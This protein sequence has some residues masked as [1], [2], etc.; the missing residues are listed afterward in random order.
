MD[1][2]A[3]AA[4]RT[5]DVLHVIGLDAVDEK[6]GN[7]EL[8]SSATKL[9][10]MFATDEAPS[11]GS[12]VVSCRDV[13]DL[14][15]DRGGFRQAKVPGKI[16]RVRNFDDDEDFCQLAAAALKDQ[17][18]VE[19]IVRTLGDSVVSPKTLGARISAR[20]EQVILK[21]IRHPAI[22]R[23]FTDL[24]D[25]IVQHGVLSAEPEAVKE[26]TSLVEVWFCKKTA[27]RQPHLRQTS[28]SKIL[29]AVAEHTK[30]KAA[31]HDINDDW[32]TPAMSATRCTEL[33]ADEVFRQAF[34]SGL[35]VEVERGGSR[36]SWQHGFMSDYFGRY[37]ETISKG[38]EA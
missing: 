24:P 11:R 19:R 12:M 25:S 27:M 38:A 28:T 9:I 37:S 36:W 34:S 32:I 1:R 26:L 20:V 6:E 31:Y 8:P 18:I 16:I 29:K 5:T 23:C 14:C 3:V 15:I 22:W 4:G 2:L 7:G 30:G 21:A 17:S 35:V 10:Q 13:D 33:T